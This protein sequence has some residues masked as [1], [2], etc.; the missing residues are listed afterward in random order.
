LLNNP[1]ILKIVNPG[2]DFSDLSRK[3]HVA[4][5]SICKDNLR[6]QVI[7]ALVEDEK[8]TQFTTCLR[9]KELDKKYEGYQMEE[10]GFI[11]FQG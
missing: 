2:R 6:E 7:K 4:A 9:E 5:M 3:Y 11:V 1:P 10:D 8:Y